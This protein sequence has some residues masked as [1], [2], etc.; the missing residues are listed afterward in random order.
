ME[1][2]NEP[3]KSRIKV[4]TAAEGGEG[5]IM[6]NNLLLKNQIEMDWLDDVLV[7]KS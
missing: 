6:V 4:V 7:W 5:H 3:P 1:E 2:G